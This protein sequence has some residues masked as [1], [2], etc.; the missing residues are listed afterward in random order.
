MICLH[1]W[2]ISRILQPHM[3]RQVLEDVF[4]WEERYELC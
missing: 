1:L 2:K 4:I 3:Y